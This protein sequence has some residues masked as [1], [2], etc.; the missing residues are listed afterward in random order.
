MGCGY[1]DCICPRE[2]TG[3]FLRALQAAG[4]AVTGYSLWQYVA[5]FEE[6]VHGMGG[7]LCRFR[8]G[9]YSELNVLRRWRGA[10]EPEAF[11]TVEEVRLG[12]ALAPGFWLKAPEGRDCGFWEV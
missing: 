1:I 8:A 5:A 4:A 6:H 11:L 9:W 12:C 10:A 2:G 7:P 3:P